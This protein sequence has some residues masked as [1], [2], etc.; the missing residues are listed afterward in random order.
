LVL[1]T[2]VTEQKAWQRP[3]S[4][5]A[6]SSSQQDSAPQSAL[7]VQATQALL[8]QAWPPPQSDASQ[9]TLPW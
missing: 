8:T 2:C 3:V 6:P 7:L 9:H 5:P 1:N 4:G